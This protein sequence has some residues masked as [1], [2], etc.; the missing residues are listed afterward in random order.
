[1]RTIP[2]CRLTLNGHPVN[3]WWSL[4]PGMDG[5]YSRF[6]GESGPPS[7]TALTAP[8]GVDTPDMGPGA[9]LGVNGLTRP[10]GRLAGLYGYIGVNEGGNPWRSGT[11]RL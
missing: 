4:D 11:P 5:Y 10:Y 6:S 8:M 7:R 1:M 9:G 2:G 3:G